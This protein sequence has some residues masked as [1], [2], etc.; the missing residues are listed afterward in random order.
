MKYGFTW[1]QDILRG[2]LYIGAGAGLVNLKW[3]FGFPLMLVLFILV[4]IIENLHTEIRQLNYN[5]NQKI[6]GEKE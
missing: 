4:H 6:K 1:S 5:D 3:Y 2:I